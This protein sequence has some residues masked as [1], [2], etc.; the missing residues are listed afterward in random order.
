MSSAH[1][2]LCYDW[3]WCDVCSRIH[4]CSEINREML[5][6][7]DG[8]VYLLGGTTFIFFALQCSPSLEPFRE[9]SAR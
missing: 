9:A 4:S 6:S 2:H 5:M 8:H 1:Y 7:T 3:C